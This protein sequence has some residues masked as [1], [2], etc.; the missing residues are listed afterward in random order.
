MEPRQ[1]GSHAL[2]LSLGARVAGIACSVQAALIADADGVLVMVFA[3]GADLP[4]RTPFMHLTVARDIIMV[5]DVLP[6]SL[7]V[8]GLALTEGV[9]PRRLRGAAVQDD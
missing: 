9:F 5:A 1:Q 4:Q 3:V 8:V 2:T 7:Q 6:P